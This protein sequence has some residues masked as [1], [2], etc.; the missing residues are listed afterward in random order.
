ME[1]SLYSSI[2]ELK[3]RLQEM[4]IFQ[5]VYPDSHLTGL[6]V[7]VYTRILSF[8]RNATKYYKSA[9]RSETR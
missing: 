6:L 7:K 3:D 2:G 9:G 1:N 4:Q 8:S 5:S